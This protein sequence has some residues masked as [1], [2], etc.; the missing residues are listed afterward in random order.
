MLNGLLSNTHVHLTS[1]KDHLT[2]NCTAWW[3][4]RSII[5]YSFFADL[6][7]GSCTTMFWRVNRICWVL[8]ER[9]QSVKIFASH[10]RLRSR[11]HLPFDIQ[12][13][14]LYLITYWATFSS[15]LASHRL[16]VLGVAFDRRL[17]AFRRSDRSQHFVAVKYSGGTMPISNV[18]LWERL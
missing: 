9:Q 2:C 16:S 13:F 4:I 10:I 15:V 14:S 17:A 7:F 12:F 11:G 3:R 18:N 1:R 6:P 5:S 8:L